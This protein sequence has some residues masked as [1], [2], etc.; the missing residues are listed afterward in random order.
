MKHKCDVSYDMNAFNDGFGCVYMV[1][2]YFEVF[3]RFSGETAENM[4]GGGSQHQSREMSQGP[5]KYKRGILTI[6]S[7]LVGKFPHFYCCN[8]LSERK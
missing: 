3:I 8:C 4:E 7:N 5:P 1:L 6:D 2:V